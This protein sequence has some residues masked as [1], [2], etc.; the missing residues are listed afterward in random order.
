M[1]NPETNEKA[2]IN[3]PVTIL[4]KANAPYVTGTN[5]AFV[6]KGDSFDPTS[7]VGFYENVNDRTP[8]GT[9]AYSVDTSK[10]DLKTPGDYSITYTVKNA[11]GL[12]RT[13][14]REVTV[15]GD[16]VPTFSY[17]FGTN[18]TKTY[19]NGDTVALNDADTKALT[20]KTHRPYCRFEVLRGRQQQFNSRLYSVFP[21]YRQQGL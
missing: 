15:M 9:T 14:K 8:L 7:G 21:N 3:V 11:A 10:L 12:T 18:N 5:K 16:T 6:N 1:T 20:F 13:I 2:T 4:D 19:K 17:R